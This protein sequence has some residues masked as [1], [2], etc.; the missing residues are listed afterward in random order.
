[1]QILIDDGMQI[2]IGTGIGKYSKYLYDNL[3]KCGLCEKV[4]VSTFVPKSTSQK[5]A[6]ITY[7]KHINSKKYRDMSARYDIVHFTN[8]LM[9]FRKNKR[10]KYVVTVHDLVSFFYPESLPVLYRFYSRFVIRYA[11]RHADV[12]LTVSHSVK[13]EIT[14]KW[15][16]YASKVKVAYPGLYD[17]YEKN[18]IMDSYRADALNGLGNNNF[19][20][21]VGTIEKRKNLG[22]VIDAFIQLK[23]VCSNEYKLVLAGRPGYGFD[24]YAERIKQ[25]GYS[26][27]I[28]CTGY[29]DSEDVR[30]LYR[31]AAAYVFPTVYEG[32]GSTQLECMINHLPLILSNIPTNREVSGDYGLFFELDS[33]DSLVEEMR[34][35]VCSE[36]DKKEMVDRA[37]E[38]CKKFR[39]ETLISDYV[40]AY[41]S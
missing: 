41:K 5:R 36:I 26:K 3:R 16:K 4:D 35:I 23:K 40:E 15:P 32:F 17:E 30:K 8:Y 20:L 28:I 1:M 34:K 18:H 22:I 39:W 13:N 38:L 21:F 14:F 25:S 19:F 24:A 29:I 27:D 10:S 7:I 9:P 31:S 33:V 11:M 12:V 2:H 37:D 6:R